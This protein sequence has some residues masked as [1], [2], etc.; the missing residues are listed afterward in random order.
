[1]SRRHQA[2]GQ[3]ARGDHDQCKRR[4]S[5][6]AALVGAREQPTRIESRKEQPRPDRRHD[7]AGQIAQRDKPR[8]IAAV[9]SL[10]DE[11]PLDPLDQPAPH[12]KGDPKAG[13]DQTDGDRQAAHDLG[14]R[15]GIAEVLQEGFAVFCKSAVDLGDRDGPGGR[16][17]WAWATG[18]QLGREPSA[19]GPVDGNDQ[20]VGA[21]VGLLR[22]EHRRLSVGDFPLQVAAKR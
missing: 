7:E 15:G 12:G 21:A 11:T 5:K 19:H 8:D 16:L 1:M 18:H 20:R 22:S 9:G 2:A 14:A 13:D 4:Q 10:D 17:Q 3:P 6:E